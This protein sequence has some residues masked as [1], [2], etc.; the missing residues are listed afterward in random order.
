MNRRASLPGVDELFGSRGGPPAPH[1]E[2]APV[3]HPDRAQRLD[4]AAH[5]TVRKLIATEDEVIVAARRRAADAVSM[6]MPEVGALLRWA[7]RTCAARHIVE[8]GAAGGV[9]GVWLLAALPDRGVLTSIEPDPQ[10]HGLAKET[11]RHAGAGT[12]VRSIPGEAATVLPRLADSSYDL[13]V[14]Q[15]ARGDYPEDLV[16][17]RRLLRPG[18][19]LVARG[20]LRVDEHGDAVGRFVE[21]LVE[22]PR[23]DA[24]VLPIDDGIALATR[25]GEQDS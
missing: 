8:V 19:M 3:T 7:A 12:R 1:A 14:L 16:H 9:T 24:V 20:V 2:Q 25:R 18:G 13:I 5:Q 15:G 17:A 11:Y 21:Q 6:P 23:F 22:D 10:A 4:D